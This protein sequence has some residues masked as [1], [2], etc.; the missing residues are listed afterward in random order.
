MQRNETGTDAQI[1]TPNRVGKEVCEVLRLARA[2]GLTLERI[3][4]DS[5]VKLPTIR[6][7][8]EDGKEPSLSRALSV[9]VV[10]GEWAVNKVL[11]L[12][13]YGGATPLDET[14]QVRPSELIAEGLAD[15]A[16]IARA[17][18]DGRFDHTEIE[19]V[20][21][22]SDRII[23]TLIPISSAGRAA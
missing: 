12:I 18:A 7:W 19:P 17:A 6:G 16:V 2:R 21:Q 5:G 20:A 10:C 11:A 8:L 23:A 14:S 1:V 3:A 15:F 9:A 22:A 13:G 4:D